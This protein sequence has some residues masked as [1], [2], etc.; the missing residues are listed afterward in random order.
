MSRSNGVDPRLEALFGPADSD[1]I[2]HVPP[3]ID[4]LPSIELLGHSVDNRATAGSFASSAAHAL[5]LEN[6]RRS[7]SEFLERFSMPVLRLGFARGSRPHLKYLIESFYPR[8]TD[9]RR[10][11]A[12][13]GAHS[14]PRDSR[15]RDDSSPRAP[16]RLE[17]AGSAQ[18]DRS[19][20]KDRLTP[21]AAVEMEDRA[22]GNNAVHGQAARGMD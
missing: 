6:V 20:R 14:H 9:H 12:G 21:R 3:S 22:N 2:I 18:D 17:H 7:Q 10:R 19:T 8:L 16:A 1:G 5:T 15:Y 13:T 11:R 4:V